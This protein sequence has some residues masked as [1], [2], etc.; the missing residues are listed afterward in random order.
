MPHFQF[1]DDLKCVLFQTEEFT[2]LLNFVRNEPQNHPEFKIRDDLLLYK[3][4]IWLNKGN[5][6]VLLLQEEYHKSPLG[7]H[8]GLAKTLSRLQQN[9]LWI[10]MK[11]DIWQY[12]TQC[13]YFQQTKYIPQG[14]H[15][16]TNSSS[17]KPLGGHGPRFYHRASQLPG[18][19]HHPDSC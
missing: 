6:F 11:Q 15:A 13:S 17:I 18:H 5:S 3:R 14:R 12:I 8:M 2:S 19:H 10:G 16:P 9:F 1:L 4:H 7:G